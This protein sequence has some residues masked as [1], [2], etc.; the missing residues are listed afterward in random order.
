MLFAL[1]S[2]NEFSSKQRYALLD[3]LLE[4]EEKGFIDHRGICDEV[5]TF[6]FEGYDTTSTCL[7]F[8]ILNLSLHPE[9]Q[10]KCRDELQNIGKNNK[11]INRKFIKIQNKIPFFR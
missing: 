10:Q 5:N 7:M 2:R 6:M 8:T 4:E 3:T 11:I 9:V 1:P